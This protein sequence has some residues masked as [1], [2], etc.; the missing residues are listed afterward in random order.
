MQSRTIIVYPIL[1]IPWRF[2]QTFSI[3]NSVP[4]GNFRAG[5][6]LGEKRNDGSQ[7]PPVR[8]VM[9]GENRNRES[10]DDG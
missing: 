3:K 6:F 2:F 8:L 1:G 4:Q 10:F 9:N 7:D 5:P